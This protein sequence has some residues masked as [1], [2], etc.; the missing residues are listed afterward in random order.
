M[1]A[2]SAGRP[3][4]RAGDQWKCECGEKIIGAL[5]INKKVAP[6]VLRPADNGNVWIGRNAEGM[7]VCATLGGPLLDKAREVG[8]QLHLNHFSDCPLREKFAR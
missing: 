1:T 8:L 7:V 3:A 6:V 4:R 2:G 5:T